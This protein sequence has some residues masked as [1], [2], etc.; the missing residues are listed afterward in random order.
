[1]NDF[2]KLFPYEI[3]VSNHFRKSQLEILVFSKKVNTEKDK[4]IPLDFISD[5]K[6]GN[7]KVVF[8]A[9]DKFDNPI[10]D[11]S[12]FQINQS[13]DKLNPSKLFTVEQINK[14][15]KKDGF[16]I[17][18]ISSA[19]LNFILQ[20]LQIMKTK[21]FLKKIFLKNNQAFKNSIQNEFENAV[22]IGFQSVFENQNFNDRIRSYSKTEEPKLEFNIESFR[23]KIQP[24]SKENWSFKLNASNTTK[25]AEILASMYDSS[26]DQFTKQDW[27]GVHYTFMNII[28]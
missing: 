28:E 27:N 9:K 7:Y 17:D 18:K 20:P 14:D 10:E 21:P 25:E 11:T 1:M 3:N 4:T 22:K 13:K 2:E 24:G 8:T 26:L 23:N 5:Y 6:S 16:V 15:P 19:F 12:N